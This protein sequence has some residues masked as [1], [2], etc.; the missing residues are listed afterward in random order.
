MLA[1][2]QK[3]KWL[4]NYW[5][6]IMNSDQLYA[7]GRIAVMSTR[8]L[9]SDK[10]TRLAE[11]STLVEALRVL[12]ENG[13]GAGT[14]IADPND[15]EVILRAE[16]DAT[17]SLLK[18]LCYDKNATQYFLCPYDYVNAKILMKSKY[19]RVSGVEYCFAN[20][21]FDPNKMQDDFVQDDYKDYT[22]NMAEACDGVDSEFAAGN[23][24]AQMIDTILDKAMF[25]DMCRYAKRSSIRLVRRLYTFQVDTTN[26]MLIYRL[27]RANCVESELTKWFVNGGKVKLDTLVKLWNNDAVAV[28]LPDEYRRF[29]ELCKVDN[30]TLAAA[31]K[32]QT[33]YRN[34]LLAEYAD[35]LTIQPVLEYFFK[36]TDEIQKL[37]RLLVDVKNGVDKEKIKEKLK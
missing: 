11:C 21:S 37:R 12:N 14:T 10:F 33:A 22:K 7:N 36:K 1:N 9:G 17:L 28:D 6:I 15:Y 34:K 20:A 18:E 32:E 27:K 25:A 3:A 19:L 8:L 35:L 30:S 23:R 5:E 26:L 31:E 16:L 29:F 24:S 13:Y 2:S 4:Q